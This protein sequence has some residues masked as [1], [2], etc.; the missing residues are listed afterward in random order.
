MNFVYTLIVVSV[1]VFSSPATKGV[2]E[3]YEPNNK[4]PLCL[5][6]DEEACQLSGGAWNKEFC[7]CEYE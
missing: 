2:T 5:P 1:L 4:S 6:G 7:I 3:T